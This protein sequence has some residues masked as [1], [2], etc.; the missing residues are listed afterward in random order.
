MEYNN[1]VAYLEIVRTRNLTKAAG[2]LYLPQSTVSNRLKALEEELGHTLVV[3]SR[4]RRSIQLT[5]FGEAFVPVAERWKALIKE[6]S[7]LNERTFVTLRIATVQ[8]VFDEI[9]ESFIYD[10]YQENPD[11]KISTRVCD[12]SYVCDLIE[13][14]EIDFGFSSYESYQS[15][16]KSEC[17]L[18]QNLC[19]VQCPDPEDDCEALNLQKLDCSKEVRV[20]GGYM[21]TLEAWRDKYLQD[22][23]LCHL[24]FNDAAQAERFLAQ[25]GYWM[26]CSIP[27]ARHICS[28]LPLK[29]FQLEDPPNPLPVYLLKRHDMISENGYLQKFEEGLRDRMQKMEGSQ[30]RR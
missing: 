3:R 13:H 21:K 14:R 4:G 6:T 16:I 29:S 8:S 17:I 2:N 20:T 11:I 7:V 30:I 18:K 12:S 5:E 23:D 25:P 10:F 27:V 26:L 1:I 9:L 24:E 28:Q 22:T 19:I 15:D